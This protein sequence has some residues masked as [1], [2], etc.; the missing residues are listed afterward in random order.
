M[1]KAALRPQIIRALKAMSTQERQ[2]ASQRL[3]QALWALPQ[4]QAAQTIATT[5]SGDFELDTAPIIE[6]A[7]AEGKTVAVPQ[8]LPHRQMAFRQLT[9]TTT[10]MTTK[11]GL[12]EPQDGVVIAPTAFDLIVVPGLRF[13]KR[14]ERLGFGG[15]YYDR[16]LPQ[17]VGY[18]VALALPA[19]QAAQP[20]WPVEDFDVMLDA[21]LNA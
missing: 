13:A 19:Q 9:A 21:V 2:A 18:K 15:G 6:R 4:W 12:Q 20:G 17:T 1:E 14:G 10:L 3:Y 11:F 7:Q 16:Y 5:L 8:T